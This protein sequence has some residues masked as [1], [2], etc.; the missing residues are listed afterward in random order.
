MSE[1]FIHF[2]KFLAERGYKTTRQRDLIARTLFQS[3]RHIS[4]E[5][6]YQHVRKQDPRIGLVTVYRT[7]KLLMEAG[8]VEERHFGEG[9]TLYEEGLREHHDHLICTHCGKIVEFENHIIEG[10]QEEV[11]KKYG[12]IILSHKHELYGLCETCQPS[13]PQGRPHENLTTLPVS[14]A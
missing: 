2:R 6:L 9:H 7:L 4:V 13:T 5:E 3:G 12:F 1:K 11:A 14:S 10:L 8:L